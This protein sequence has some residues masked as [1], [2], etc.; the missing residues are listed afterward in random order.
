MASFSSSF[1]SPH[2][3]IRN[4]IEVLTGKGYL[5][6]LAAGEM[7][8]DEFILHKKHPARKGSDEGWLVKWC[9]VSL[10]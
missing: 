8:V 5:M 6:C 9:G 2:H 4:E 7:S 1:S 3:S 10:P